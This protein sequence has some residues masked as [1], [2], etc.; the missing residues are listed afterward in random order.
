L[1]MRLI[2]RFGQIV[3]QEIAQVVMA[4]GGKAEQ[5]IRAMNAFD[6]MQPPPTMAVPDTAPQKVA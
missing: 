6:R 4:V 1:A 2:P 5:R 3:P